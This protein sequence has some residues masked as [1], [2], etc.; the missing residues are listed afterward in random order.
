MLLKKVLLLPIFTFG[1]IAFLNLLLGEFFYFY[2]WNF[3]AILVS[4][5]IIPILI[6]EKKETVPVIHVFG[7]FIIFILFSSIVAF[8]DFRQS[9]AYSLAE[10][11]LFG[12]LVGIGVVALIMLVK[13]K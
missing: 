12:I 11:A 8:F 3:L 9:Q 1:A 4:I 2:I 6:N 10:S 5:A 13:G 7:V